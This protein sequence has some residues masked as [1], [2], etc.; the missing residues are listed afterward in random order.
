MGCPRT[1]LLLSVSACTPLEDRVEIFDVEWCADP[2]IETQSCVL[3]GDTFDLAACGAT[4]DGDSP[5]RIRLLGVDAPEVAHEEE[6]ADC[7]GAEATDYL[8]DLLRGR[9]LHLEF[10]EECEGK[11]GRTLAWVFIQGD[12][13]DPLREELDIFGALGV[14]DDGSFEVLVNELVVRA[15]YAK[16]YEDLDEGRYNGRLYEAAQQAASGEEGL[17]G[18]CDG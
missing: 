10:D 2:R 11:F 4:V 17:W 9:T 16:L 5:E 14:T 18:V 8:T 12:A 7:F 1:I 3:D 13:D 15:G 6:P